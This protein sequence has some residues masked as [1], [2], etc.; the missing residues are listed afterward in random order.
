[1]LER[2][3]VGVLYFFYFTLRRVTRSAAWRSDRADMS[4]TILCRAGSEGE[5]RGLGDGDG[6]GGGGDEEEE[7]VA[8]AVAVA[9]ARTRIHA[10]VLCAETLCVAR[11]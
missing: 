3:R 1:M 11:Q 10:N 8:S 6:D 4:S 9:S 7:G 2:R 5:T